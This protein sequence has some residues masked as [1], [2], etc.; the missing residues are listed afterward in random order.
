MRWNSRSI[1]SITILA[2]VVEFVVLR[3]LP[4]FW[5]GVSKAYR[6][7]WIYEHNFASLIVPTQFNSGHPPLWITSIAIFWT[8]LGKSVWAARLL[9]LIV[10]I[11]VGYQL[12]RLCKLAFEPVVPLA[13]FFLVIIDPTLMAQTTI[14][15]NDMLLLFFILLGLNS[16]WKGQWLW[17]TLALSGML[18]TNL[19]GIYCT[20]AFC[21]IHALFVRYASLSF[22]RKMLR[23]YAIGLVVFG[24]FLIAQ[25]TELGWVLISKN[26]NYAGHREAAG[27]A[28]VA[29]NAAA[30]F[31]NILDFG[32]VFLWVP[33]L[34]LLWK[35]FRKQLTL[36]LASKR[37]LLALMVFT[38]VFFLGFVPFS[39]PMGPRYLMICFLLGAMLFGNLLFRSNKN[40]T[41]RNGVIT[42]V[43]VGLLTGH[44]W[45]YPSTISQ[46]WDSSLAYLRYFKQEQAML[47][48]LKE[49]GISRDEVGTHLPINSRHMARLDGS[50]KLDPPF[51][52]PDFEKNR[53]Y[54]HS[55]VENKTKDAGIERLA[56]DWE[57]VKTFSSMGVFLTLYKNPAR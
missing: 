1:L 8:V 45:I 46:G 47:D 2:L 57:P 9:L 7:N 28:R 12:L 14:L 16:L 52:T 38:S 53:Y 20:I 33:L 11:G 37:I 34:L 49:Q 18:L 17:Y 35:V 44:L 56:K 10:N 55:N 26:K 24:G 30:Y 5:D 42:L 43:A 31:K 51:V 40:Q 27:I 4:F 3:D 6:A 32:R 54:L 19:R 23:A 41:L 21:L 25:Y 48:Y 29:K 13:F 39:N 15:N 36:S 50:E 22:D